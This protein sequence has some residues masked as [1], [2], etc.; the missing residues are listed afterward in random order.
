MPTTAAFDLIK[1]N[2]FS[3]ISRAAPSAL[4]SGPQVFRSAALLSSARKVSISFA[5][6]RSN[7]MS[8][9]HLRSRRVAL[10]SLTPKVMR[11]IR[12]S[13]SLLQLL[14][15]G[16]HRANRS[17]GNDAAFAIGE[18]LAPGF[19]P[20]ALDGALRPIVPG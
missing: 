14:A 13:T 10:R 11:L 19:F 5:V 18:G 2:V 15:F 7:V 9:L 8:P 17:F 6:A 3:R 1:Y 16:R 12:R 20:F 4:L